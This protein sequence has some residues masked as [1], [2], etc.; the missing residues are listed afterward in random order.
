MFAQVEGYSVL[1]I[2]YG[3]DDSSRPRLMVFVDGKYNLI[4]L[5]L[6][7]LELSLLIVE[8]HVL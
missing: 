4:Y 3:F 7:K 1:M 5:K 8:L 2:I 6:G